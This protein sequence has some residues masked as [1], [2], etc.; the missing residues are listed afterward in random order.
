MA[1]SQHS[2]NVT[3]QDRLFPGG[4]EVSALMRAMD[5]SRTPLGPAEQWPNALRSIV[6]VLLT[7]RYAMWMGWGPQLTFLYNDAYAAMTL[8]AKHP[9]ALGRASSEV[10]PEIWPEIGPRIERV[11]RTGEATW[12][13]ALLLFLERN[14]YQEETYHTFSYSPLSDDDG[15]VRGH[16]CVVIEDTDRVIGNRRLAVLKELASQLATTNRVNDVFAASE[17]CLAIDSR[18]LPFSLIY[19]FEGDRA[20]L[21]SRT[22]VP[23]GDSSAPEVIN[24][25]ELAKIWSLPAQG[26]LAR[27]EI[28][29]ANLPADW[30]SWGRQIARVF[31]AP[32]K[33]SESSPFGVMIAGAN[34]CR[35]TDEAYRTFISLYVGQITAGLA[36]AR[37]YEEA[38]QRAEALAEID[39]AKTLFFTNVSHEFRTP[40]TL[41][42]GPVQDLLVEAVQLTQE[43]QDKLGIAYR[44]CLRL[45][46]L[47]NALLDFSRIEAGR[48][49]A[50]FEPTDLTA[51][52]T[53]LAAAFRSLIE[54]AGL[55]FEVKCDPLGAIAYVDR[56]MWEK[57]VL[58][59]V[60]NAFKFTFEGKIEVRLYEA[61]DRI[62]LSVS[63][64]GIGIPEDELP[65]IFD[66]F[67][68]IEGSRSRTYEGSGIGL[69]LVDELVKMHGGELRV[70]SHVG[71]GSTFTVSIPAGDAHLPKD[72]IGT[73]RPRESSATTAALFV[74]EAQR[75]DG[76]P[77]A[78]AHRTPVRP[79]EL[80][81][82]ATGPE[83]IG[84]GARIL[85][86][87]DNADMREY[88][89]HLLGQ[90]FIVETAVDGI[91]ALEAARAHPPD[92]VLTDVMMP[93]L[94]GFGLLAALRADSQT[95]T[96]PVIMLS[97]RAGEEARLE[98]L[99]R[100]ADDYL[101]KPFSARELLGRIRSQLE[102]H[103]LRTQAAN[104][105]EQLL[106]REQEARREA[107]EANRSKD[108][109]LAMLGHELRNPL[110]PILTALQLMQLRKG[111]PT[112][113]E[114]TIIER[115][116][117]HLT[118][119]VDD[120][121][122]I[123]RITRGNIRLKKEQVELATV[124]AKAI[125]M[126]S[127]LIEERM[128]Y[129]SV[130]VPTSGLLLNGDPARLVQAI[131]NLLTNAAKYTEPRGRIWIKG[132]R[133]G[134][135]LELRVRDNGIGMSAE[136]VSHVFDLFYQGT[137]RS[138][139]SQGGLGIGLAIVRSLIL[140]H[141]G[142]VEAVSEG[143]GK[144]SE[145]IVRLPAV[146][147]QSLPKE[148][149]ARPESRLRNPQGGLRVF[150]VDDNE[151]AALLLSEAL[152]DKGH[153]T[154]T[155]FDPVSA[156]QM[157]RDFLPEV[158]LLDIGLPVMD[159]YE[160]AN[161]I[162]QI[163]ELRA[164]RLFA[165]T[166][167]GQDSDRAQSL[168]LGFERHLAKPIEIETLD[169]LIR[170]AGTSETA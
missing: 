32:I 44:N 22:N 75:W 1:T 135:H 90:E 30:G 57:I 24:L 125:E 84:R 154:R 31:V 5:W 86:A 116:V 79:P 71:R 39:R 167:Y 107:E 12:D 109:F 37:A 70:S 47:V 104:E 9:W 119:L 140:L 95:K 111:G 139:R 19:Q 42:L 162:R 165:L 72:R 74:E 65:R 13:E 106:T 161:R 134:N 49:Q 2:E 80:L 130:S 53:D 136:M 82:D 61:A 36:N 97:A 100:G 101:I 23:I 3:F 66:R 63:D 69:A 92:L 78:H 98:G 149:E 146:E 137:Q 64:T 159:G 60:S 138:D 38:N 6:R 126:T 151:D 157:V 124:V 89:R 25:K 18:D 170:K 55:S 29:E 153:L 85:L 59:L 158:I 152:T 88:V 110:A 166:G 54:R 41:I 56:E 96:I 103:R 83:S 27:I 156:L 91:Q 169:S 11:L 147:G 73:A 148:A 112:D 142:T 52:T 102:L 115:Q 150:I 62:Q 67:H 48:V 141:G 20:R 94:D 123:S 93:K 16:F 35:P 34:P 117:Y 76:R 144:G 87:D 43:H 127:P 10:W 46:K 160:L 21:V 105:R 120:L 163:P 45:Q 145:F 108:E 129:L 17:K 168:E 114:R 51:L 77:D 15:T 143:A 26:D 164:A 122:D 121:L 7:S 99:E 28:V 33:Q 81:D 68:R 8:G 118:R 133:Q 113:R 4:G 128:H 58:N 155:A 132:S 131:S 14:S 50:S 40:L